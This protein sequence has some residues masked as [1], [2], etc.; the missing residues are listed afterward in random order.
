MKKLILAAIAA[1]IAMGPALATAAEAAPV[2]QRREVTTV[3]QQPNGRTVVTKRTV[4]RNNRGQQQRFRTWNRGDRFDQRQAQNYQRLSNYRQYR[5]S[6]PTRGA[7]WAR[8]GRDA[9]LLR[10]GQVIEVRTRTFR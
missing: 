1:T 8:S 7:Y 3:R 2:Q 10:N 6:A 9:V 5:L 4:V